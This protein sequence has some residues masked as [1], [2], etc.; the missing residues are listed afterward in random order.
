MPGVFEN[1]LLGGGVK[2]LDQWFDSSPCRALKAPVRTSGPVPQ[3]VG[4][5][6]LAFPILW[7]ITLVRIPTIG[8]TN[9]VQGHFHGFWE[10]CRQGHLDLHPVCAQ[11]VVSPVTSPAAVRLHLT[12]LVATFLFGPVGGG[13]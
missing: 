12:P 10:M 1:W 13:E 5:P 6:P 3:A 8:I 11:G 2:E 4:S 7:I 9:N